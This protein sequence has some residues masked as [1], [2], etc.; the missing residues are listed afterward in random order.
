MICKNYKIYLDV[1]H[2]N[3]KKNTNNGNLNFKNLGH[4]TE[5]KINASKAKTQKTHFAKTAVNTPSK[6]NMVIINH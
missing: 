6:K 3:K 4:R 5:G 2:P 1:V